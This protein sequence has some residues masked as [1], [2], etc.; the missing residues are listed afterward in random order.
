MIMNFKISRDVHLILDV[1]PKGYEVAEHIS[2]KFEV[3]PGMI[4][5]LKEKYP[6][7]A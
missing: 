1:N 2:T 5:K 4:S 6:F 3:N 7:E